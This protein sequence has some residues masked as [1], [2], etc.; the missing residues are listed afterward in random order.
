MKWLSQSLARRVSGFG[1]NSVTDSYVLRPTS[2]GDIR[3][4]LDAARAGGLKVTLR[5]A[6]RSYGDPAI[7]RE[8]VVL[9][10]SDFNQILA[11]DPTTG[12]VTCQGGVTLEQL[13][14]HCLSDGWF[15]PVTSG[16]MFP[17]L[18][19]ALGMNIH[20]KNNFRA[21]TLGEHVLSLSVLLV[22]GETL[23]L[24]PA[25]E[26]FYAFISG[27]GLLGIIVEVSLQM[28]RV[29]TPMLAV[30]GRSAESLEQHFSAFEAFAEEADYMVSW[31]DCFGRGRG[32]FHWARYLS[33]RGGEA[34]PSL[35][36]PTRILG[37]I[38]KSQVWRILKLLNNRSGMR[39]LNAAK[40]YSAKL[41]DNGKPKN[42]TLIQFSYLLDYV[43]GW[44]KS[45]AHG[46]HQFQVFVPAAHA[47]PTFR[48]LL[49]MQQDAKLESFLGVMKRH[50]ADRFLLSHAVD[51]YSL[52]MDFR[53]TPKNR[54]QL[55]DLLSEM[56]ELVIANGGRFYLAKD[57]VLTAD[58]YARAIGPEKLAEFK[59]LRATLD[60]EGLLT[61]EMAKR[62]GL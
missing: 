35:D 16:T 48:A 51:G 17:T 57:S 31:V 37:L 15:L 14:R 42:Q 47:L 20:G 13:W 25:D 52:A 50:R 29:P 44:Q 28:H 18:A 10:F 6:G 54:E 53:I 34:P 41:T 7:A 21:G 62:L 12:I 58:Q 32:L 22:S 46:F 26:L 49:A 40:H 4:G 56:A 36:L 24:T 23:V 43:P 60:P 2:V 55:N 5:G 8:Q 33:A 11:W 45:Y 9:D 27:A 38:P 30:E 3:A 61:S 39:L 59:R 1:S 19:G